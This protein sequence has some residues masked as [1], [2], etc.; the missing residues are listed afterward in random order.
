MKKQ[1]IIDIIFL[2]ENI[3]LLSK[4]NNSIISLFSVNK[5]MNIKL[6]KVALTLRIHGLDMFATPAR[7]MFI[8][9]NTKMLTNM[10]NSCFR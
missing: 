6:S 8:V 1:F 3:Y 10:D 9:S 7:Y 4:I 2:F 5:S